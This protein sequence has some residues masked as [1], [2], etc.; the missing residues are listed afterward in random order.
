MHQRVVSLLLT[1]LF[2]SSINHRTLDSCCRIAIYR[3]RRKKGRIRCWKGHSI[4]SEQKIDKKSGRRPSLRFWWW[5]KHLVNTKC[6][7]RSPLHSKSSSPWFCDDSPAFS[8]WLAGAGQSERRTPRHNSLV[9]ISNMRCRGT[10]KRHGSWIQQSLTHT[11]RESPNAKFHCQ[12]HER[13][14]V[15][16]FGFLT[17]IM[18]SRLISSPTTFIS[19]NN[20]THFIKTFSLI[21][22]TFCF[23]F[24]S[25]PKQANQGYQVGQSQQSH[26]SWLKPTI[27]RK[28]AQII[29]TTNVVS[30]SF[31][32]RPLPVRAT[33]FSLPKMERSSFGSI[34]PTTIAF[35]VSPFPSSK[36][37]LSRF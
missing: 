21:D 19:P 31:P 24:L 33:S 9:T 11:Q 10:T 4:V 36:H 16:C 25:C 28:D 7:K 12:W 1:V 20:E 34:P 13:V 15:F 29:S 22:R 3:L 6:H 5:R 35:P 30:E 37:S 23:A 8:S 2:G 32:P 27:A 18:F 26:E 14:V 17:C